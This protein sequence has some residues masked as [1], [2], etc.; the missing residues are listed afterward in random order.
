MP[1]LSSATSIAVGAANTINLGD[2]G[3][4]VNINSIWKFGTANALTIHTKTGGTLTA[5]ALT[6]PVDANGDLTLP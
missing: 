5:A 6:S 2:S 1:L 3:T 4:S